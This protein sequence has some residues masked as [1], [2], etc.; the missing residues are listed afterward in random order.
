ML[1][2][3]NVIWGVIGIIL[4]G[5]AYLVHNKKMYDLISGYNTSSDEEKEE[6][7]KNGYLLY[8]GRFLWGMAFIWLIGFLF[9]LLDVPYAMEIQVAIFLLYTMGGTIL[10]SKYSLEKKK[11]RNYIFSISLTVIVLTFVSGLFFFGM[12]TTEVTISEHSISFSGMYSY[13]LKLEDIESAEIIEALPNNMR[14]TNGFGT[15][16]R[17]LGHFSSDELGKGRMYV[18]TK[19]EPYI[20]LNTKEG[21]LILNSKDE[22]ETLQWYNIINE[23]IQ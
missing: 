5:M 18:C 8:M 1:M 15:S 23:R 2:G 21:F 3:L 22:Q 13:E 9:I 12:R 17:A 4:C 10:S 19:Y 14:R 6:Y 16:T 20:F 7:R 11:Q